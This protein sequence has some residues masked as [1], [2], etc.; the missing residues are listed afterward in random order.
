[1]E[2]KAL[3]KLDDVHGLSEVIS[4]IFKSI[5]QN[6]NVGTLAIFEKIE[7]PYSEEKGYGL[8]SAKPFPLKENENQYT[9]T[10][11]FLDDR[12][13][14]EK[15]ILTVLYTDL[16]FGDNLR[17]SKDTPQKAKI[18]D[19]HTRMSGVIV[20]NPNPIDLKI[21]ETVGEPNCI[22]IEYNGETFLVQKY[23]SGG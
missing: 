2:V 7:E 14:E 10:C 15:Q 5:V 9:I 17:V 11:Y 22:T 16:V 4:L 6:V 8:V 18:K 20:S 19:V 3:G 13:F 21:H 23:H 12:E 1:M